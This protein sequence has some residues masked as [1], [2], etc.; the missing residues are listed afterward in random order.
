VTA[1]LL[2]Q[3]ADL[4]QKP[5]FDALIRAMAPPRSQRVRNTIGAI[6]PGPQQTAACRILAGMAADGLGAAL[7]RP[8]AAPEWGGGAE[9]KAGA[10][11]GSP[12]WGPTC[13]PNA[14]KC[15]GGGRNPAISGHFCPLPERPAL[16]SPAKRRLTWPQTVRSPPPYS[17]DE[18]ERPGAVRRHDAAMVRRAPPAWRYPEAWDMLMFRDAA[19]GRPAYRRN[20][21]AAAREN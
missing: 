6:V 5:R 11:V 9:V 19:G 8:V 15:H 3:L 13:G 21:D 2:E 20:D 7:A 18:P 4:P 16:T 14:R 1:S 10:V 17:A 12:W